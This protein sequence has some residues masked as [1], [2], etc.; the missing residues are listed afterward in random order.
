MLNSSLFGCGCKCTSKK[1][2]HVL[3][4]RLFPELKVTE[5]GPNKSLQVINSN[6]SFEFEITRFECT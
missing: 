3:E 2:M 4:E 6:E 1:T 5:Y